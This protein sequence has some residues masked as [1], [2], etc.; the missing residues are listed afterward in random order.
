MK[1][2]NQYL[3]DAQ[4]ILSQFLIERGYSDDTEVFCV[5]SCKTL[6]NYKCL[7]SATAEDCPYFE[8]TYDGNHNRWYVDVYDKQENYEVGGYLTWN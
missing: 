7:L 5:W 1:T 3:K 2:N 8:L 4:Y 6:Q